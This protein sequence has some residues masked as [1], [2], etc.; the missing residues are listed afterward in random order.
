ML[1]LE[2]HIILF[3]S[4]YVSRDYFF[5]NPKLQTKRNKEAKNDHIKPIIMLNSLPNWLQLERRKAA[6][7]SE[8]NW[9]QRPMKS[10]K[11]QTIGM[12]ADRTF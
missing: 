7:V 8:G 6:E 11:H 3:C 4:G 10:N 1:W 9:L 12:N 2:D 5:K